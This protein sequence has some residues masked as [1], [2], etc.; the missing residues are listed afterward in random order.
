VELYKSW[1]QVPKNL[2]SETWFKMN[3][4]T[5]PKEPVAQVYQMMNHTYIDLYDSVGAE[6]KLPPERSSDRLDPESQSTGYGEIDGRLEQRYV[7]K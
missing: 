6:P 7:L 2:K 3:K 5:R 4:L 1:P